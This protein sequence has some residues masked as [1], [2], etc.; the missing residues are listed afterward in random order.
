MIL[1][2]DQGGWEL[3]CGGSYIYMPKMHQERE[4]EIRGVWEVRCFP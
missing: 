3:G 1:G 2:L 4:W